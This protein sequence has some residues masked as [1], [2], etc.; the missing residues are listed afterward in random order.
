MMYLYVAVAW[1]PIVVFAAVSALLWTKELLN[2]PNCQDAKLVRNLRMF[3]CHSLLVAVMSCVALK[4]SAQLRR[5][6]REGRDGP[7]SRPSEKVLR[8]APPGSMARIPTVPYDP[9]LFGAEDGRRYHGECPICLG[10]F[11]AGDEIKV[12]HCGH[13]YHKD[14]LGRWLRRER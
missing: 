2:A 3:S 8:R 4:W 12:P 14:C 13:A 6:H 5:R 9:E 7:A 1:V 11:E 10:D